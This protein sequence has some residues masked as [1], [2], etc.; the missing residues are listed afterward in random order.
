M[1]LSKN[2]CIK[3]YLMPSKDVCIKVYLMLSKDVRMYG[4][5]VCMYGQLIVSIYEYTNVD[6]VCM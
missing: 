2:V 5:S 4:M 6:G 1:I 3:V